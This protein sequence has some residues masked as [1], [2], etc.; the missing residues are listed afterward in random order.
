MYSAAAGNVTGAFGVW[1]VFATVTVTT[2]VALVLVAAA[3]INVWPNR[4]KLDRYAHAL[5]GATLSLCGLAML[6]GL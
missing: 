5:A 6:L 3:G 1:A 2:M 4:L